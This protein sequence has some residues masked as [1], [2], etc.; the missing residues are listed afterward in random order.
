MP[1]QAN[2]R[3]QAGKILGSATSESKSRAAR[4][5]GKAGG[6]PE[7][8]TTHSSNKNKKEDKK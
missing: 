4:E 8:S 5:N 3:S 6:R 7:G 2:S 1:E